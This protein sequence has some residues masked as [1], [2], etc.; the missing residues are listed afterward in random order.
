MKTEILEL[1]SSCKLEAT[2]YDGGS[3]YVSIEYVEHST[4]HWHSDSNTSLDV[5]KEQAIEIIEFLKRNFNLQ[6][7]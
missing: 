5:S 3:T 7:A 6:V 4:D 1:S 2:S